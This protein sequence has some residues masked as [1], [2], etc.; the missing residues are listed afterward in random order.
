MKLLKQRY[1]EEHDNQERENTALKE[2]H[3]LSESL[4]EKEVRVLSEENRAL[5][6]DRYTQC[7]LRRL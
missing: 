2:K 1:K 3:K 4:H 5:K 6:V 7:S